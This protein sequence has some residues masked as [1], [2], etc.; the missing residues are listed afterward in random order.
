MSLTAGS[1]ERL[2]KVFEAL[3]GMHF[4][5]RGQVNVAAEC[6]RAVRRRG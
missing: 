3:L 6:K 5:A 4:A 2:I 1:L